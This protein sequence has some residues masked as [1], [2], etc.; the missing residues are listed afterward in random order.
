MTNFNMIVRKVYD[1]EKQ[2]FNQVVTHPL[3]S[4]GWGEFRQKTGVE[5][6][7]LGEFSGDKLVN[8]FQV[9]F[10]DVPK[11]SWE[12]GY[13]PK[14]VVPSEA[15]LAALKQLGK[16]H[17]ALFIK[18]E[19]NV[20]SFVDQDLNN[21]GKVQKYFKT[22]GGV[23][24]RPLFA[25]YTFKLDLTQSEEELLA[26]MKSKTRY[27]V[28][29]AERHGVKVAE[30]NSESAFKEYLRLTFEE[31]TKRQGFYAHTKEYHQKMWASMKP[32]GIA[33]LLT[34]IYQGKV[35]VAW[36]VFV[37]NGVLFYP[38]GASSN[39]FREV[40]ASNLMMWEAIK[41]GKKWGCR[42]F[43]MWGS[44]GPDASER[45]PWYGFH[46][47]K[48]GYGGILFKSVGTF[49]LVLEPRWYK[50]YRVV[51]KWRWRWL[52]LRASLGV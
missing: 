31:T 7:R 30:D 44:L 39:E 27:N 10:H 16:E 51:E 20:G 6:V 17:K 29:L 8:G 26:G 48:E 45:D 33:H 34:A 9:T 13:V 42:E 21:E 24:G 50:I 3:Q 37:F 2:A 5:V 36:I 41:L 43:D 52:R 1:K 4:W 38:Y 35:V 23:L 46:K 14:S 47:F 12:I 28:R 18:L 11:T 19:P 49:D 15:A 32:T 25:Q 22:H 40:M